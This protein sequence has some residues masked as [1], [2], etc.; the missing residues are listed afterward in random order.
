MPHFSVSTDGEHFSS[1]QATDYGL[2]LRFARFDPRT[3]ASAVTSAVPAT[4]RASVGNQLFIV[5]CWTQVLADWREALRE[6]GAEVHLFLPNH[7]EVVS[8]DAA[9]RVR[10]AALP[11]VRALT[12]FHPA[13]KLEEELLAGLGEGRSGPIT[14]NLL[15]LRRGGQAPVVSWIEANG[16]TI[17]HVSEP[18]Y[19]MSATLDFQRLPALAALDEVQ[20]IDRWFA[21]AADM[22]HARQLHGADYVEATYGLTGQGVRVEVMDGGF[23]TTH[24]DMQDFLIHNNNSPVE[25][26]T[27]TSGIVVG[28]G[29]GNVNAR[30][31]AP[32]AFLVVADYDFAYAGGS[33]Y[34]HT[35]QL[36]NPALAYKCVLQSNSWGSGLTTAYNSSSQNMDLILFDHARISICQSQSNNGDRNSRPEAWAKNII[37][38]G[39]VL[40]RNT[41][42]MVDDDWAGFASIGPAADGRIKPDVASFYDSILCPDMVG[43]AGY[44]TT[45]YYTDFG[46]TS[47]ATPIVAGHLALIYQ[48]WNQGLFGNAHP[49]ATVFENAPYNTTAKALLI[50]GAKQWT[51]NGAAHDLTRV[52]QG[53]GAANLERLVTTPIFVVDEADVLA[54]LQSKSYVLVVVPGEAQLHATLVY[55]DPPGT[56]SASQHRINDLDLVLTSPSNV[57]YGGNNGL[58]AN[59]FSPPGGSAD[60]K[61]TVENVLL[62]TPEVGPWTVTVTATDVNQDTHLETPAEDVDFALVVTGAELPTTPPAA[63]SHLRG[64]ASSHRAG[65]SFQDESFDEQGFELERSPDGLVFAPLVTLAAGDDAHDDIGLTP[66]TSYFYRLR[67]FNAFGVSAWSNAIEVKTTKSDVSAGPP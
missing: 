31:A 28:K 59:M 65:L 61:N 32:D 10:V 46:G 35:G 43:V 29:L 64:R 20:W 53:W 7:A 22:N 34:S 33:R 60:T 47:G 17:E 27:C 57:V 4:L 24:P 39:A 42:T 25:H 21:P 44:S 6:A 38:V 5:Q 66:G 26:G 13:Y 8:L 45:N 48:M 58:L 49:G 40:H 50:N 19:L 23:D 52:H 30:G 12:P 41:T 2:R 67:A 11:F 16:G 9:A 18:T 37:S 14:V 56:T 36:V 62:Q 54:N 1:A 3:A 15:T 51:F 55:R 63:P